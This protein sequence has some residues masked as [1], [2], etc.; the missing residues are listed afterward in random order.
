M[1]LLWFFLAFALPD[2]AIRDTQGQLRHPLDARTSQATVLFFV[3]HDCPISNGSAHE[4]AR[5]CKDYRS[6]GVSCSLIYVDPSTTDE[7]ANK[8]AAEYG[9]GDYPRLID[10]KHVLVQATGATV[11]PESVLIDHSGKV[12][13]KG[14]IDDSY[15]AL[16]QPRREVRNAY[17]REA[18]DAVIAGKAVARPETKPLGCYISDLAALGK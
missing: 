13:Y 2:L 3:T 1:Y 7:Q 11:T 10:R 9:H 17:L 5:I 18:L 15:P 4:I 6:K 16:G 14:R 12:V 8:H